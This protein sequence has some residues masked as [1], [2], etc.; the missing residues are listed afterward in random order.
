MDKVKKYKE[1]LERNKEVIKT[2]IQKRVDDFLKSVD[3]IELIL[4]SYSS[5]YL[6]QTKNKIFFTYSDHYS[7]N[8]GVDMEVGK[9]SHPHMNY[10]DRGYIKGVATDLDGY[11][12]LRNAKIALE[13]N[14][15]IVAKL[16]FPKLR[17]QKRIAEAEAIQN[18]INTEL[19]EFVKEQFDRINKELQEITG[20]SLLYY[21][22]NI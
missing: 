9:L 7:A 8:S 3:T 17:S 12:K 21:I 18:K 13:H 5:P 16:Y 6:G 2:G 14:F 19:K 22:R 1:T 4:F 11:I 20:C 10:E 15:D